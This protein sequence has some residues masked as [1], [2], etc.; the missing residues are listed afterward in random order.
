[1]KRII[2]LSFFLCSLLLLGCSKSSQS[3]TLICEKEVG[4]HDL[5]YEFKDKEVIVKRTLNALGLR[6]KLKI[7][8]SD[9]SDLDKKKRLFF[10]KEDESVIPIIESTEG[11]IK[12]GFP[13]NE[14]G[15]QIDVLNRA[16]LEITSTTHLYGPPIEGLP[17]NPFSLIY[18]CKEPAI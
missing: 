6:A 8:E 5:F 14:T 10:L 12:F 3:F 9:E 2:L 4:F 15:E 16:N 11:F 13:K 17:H 7:I 18:K 1:M